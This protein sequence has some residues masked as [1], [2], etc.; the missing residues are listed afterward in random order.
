M[1]GPLAELA[2]DAVHPL[3][4]RTIWAL[5]ADFDHGAQSDA[6]AGAGSPQA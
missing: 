4:R 5:W 1:L 3:E 6:G 2:P